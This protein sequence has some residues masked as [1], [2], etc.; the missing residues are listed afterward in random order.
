M[1]IRKINNDETSKVRFEFK[2]LDDE[3]A[4]CF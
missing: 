4:V 3:L 1:I 2:N